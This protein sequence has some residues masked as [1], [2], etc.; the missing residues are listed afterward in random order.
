[1]EQEALN[2]SMQNRLAT[3]AFASCTLQGWFL[4]LRLV[5]L[6]NYLMTQGVFVS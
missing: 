1:M 2:L 6:S 3:I 4:A 5:T